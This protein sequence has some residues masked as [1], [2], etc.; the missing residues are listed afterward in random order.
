MRSVE[1]LSQALRRLDGRSY[2]GYRELE[3]GWAGRD[4]ELFLDHAQGD[5]FAA[6]SRLRVRIPMRRADLPRDL[7][8]RPVRRLALADFLARRTARAIDAGRG[9]GRGSGRS[10]RIRI[11]SGGAAVL[12]RSAVR[13]EDDF[14]EAR[15]EAGLPAAGRRILGGEADALLT[16][17]LPEI[18]RR[19][20]EASALPETEAREFVECVENQEFLRAHLGELGLVAFV[21]D[22]SRLPRLS[23]VT[24]RPLAWDRTVPFESPDS[25][26][27][28]VELPHPVRI[29]EREPS[30]E[31][32]GMGVRRGITLVVG[33]GYH[34][35]STLLRA[36]ER[37]VHP[38]VP[39]DGR[40]Y[41]VSDPDLVKVRAEDGRRIERVDISAFIGRL[42]QGRDTRVFSSNDAS[43]STS[44]AASIVEAL[45]AGARVLLLDE[46]TSATN[47]MIRDA[48]MQ[49]L[50]PDGD[51]PI[52]PFLDRIEALRDRLGV[53]TV[54]VMGG[55]GDYFDVAD[56]V[57]QMRGYRAIDVTARARSIASEHPTRRRRESSGELTPPAPRAPLAASFDP[58]RARGRIR[59]EARSRHT[60][61]F[62]DERI[63]LGALDQLVDRSQTRAIGRAL[64][65]LG[66]RWVDGTR[67]LGVL[68]DA[69]EAE[70]D[71]RGLDVLASPMGRQAPD[72]DENAH[73]GDL[74]RP[75]RHE[76]A[77]AI[78]RL[79]SLRVHSDPSE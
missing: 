47:F 67:S 74:A 33:G 70:L 48:R 72:T 55:S 5:P 16:E 63:E 79:R 35:K 36:L 4:F 20:L 69:L 1:A 29:R 59:I 24:E 37:G 8:D 3:G 40:E 21:A 51:E 62:G 32:R 23:G 60:I 68:L 71:A 46:D 18:A 19:G 56:H 38:H 73:P 42:P 11:D 64:H 50:V 54:L 2:K 7:F 66:R 15:L 28:S 17:A 41:V 13:L 76:I 6:P 78:N 57:I 26:R 22:G 34:G 58:E 77:A 52:T 25:L 27:V 30:R 31:V 65:L 9:R 45:E 75:R 39:G 53:S 44:Q 61:G 43:G 14:V 12:A 49:A 10:G